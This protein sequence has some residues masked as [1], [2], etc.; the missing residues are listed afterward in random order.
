MRRFVSVGT[1]AGAICVTVVVVVVVGMATQKQSA[2]T[3][4]DSWTS[5]PSGS[6]AACASRLANALSRDVHT[7]P[8]ITTPA[9]LEYER[10]FVTN[11][12]TPPAGFFVFRT[13]SGNG[14]A[15]PQEI[16]LRV[17]PLRSGPYDTAHL[18]GKAG[19]LPS[20]RPYLDLSTTLRSGP[21]VERLGDFELVISF[22]GI[23]TPAAALRTTKLALLDSVTEA[24]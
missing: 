22:D 24:K 2:N 11:T 10:G 19:R 13:T 7:L 12:V 9:G 1:V 20:G 21:F 8:T 3:S 14:G 18:G 5:C 15:Q 4:G 23:R 16:T 6:P 17:S